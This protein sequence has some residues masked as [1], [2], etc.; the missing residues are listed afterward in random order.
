MSI[1]LTVSNL[2]KRTTPMNMQTG[3]NGFIHVWLWGGVYGQYCVNLPKFK[4]TLGTNN[5]HIII[6]I[7]IMYTIPNAVTSSYPRLK[8]SVV[9]SL[10]MLHVYL[11]DRLLKAGVLID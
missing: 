4:Y 5:S 7:I 2:A 6:I 3:H 9:S 8:Q 11:M 10:Y 1:A